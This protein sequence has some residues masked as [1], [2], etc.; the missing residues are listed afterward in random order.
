MTL[1]RFLLLLLAAVTLLASA[2]AGEDG[3]AKRYKLV[4]SVPRANVRVTLNGGAYSA[5]SRLDGSF[6]LYDVPAGMYLVHVEDRE[7]EYGDV[8]VDMRVEGKVKVHAADDPARLLPYPLKMEPRKRLAYFEVVPPFAIS[9]FF[10]SWSSIMMVVMLLMVIVCPKILGSIDP[11]T[12]KEMQ[13]QMNKDA[14]SM[15]PEN[16]LKSMKT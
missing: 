4:G 6:A 1:S 2:A 10:S 13:E 14:E 9:S 15:R 3:E 12:L 5:H 16:L 11:E 7:A 8:V